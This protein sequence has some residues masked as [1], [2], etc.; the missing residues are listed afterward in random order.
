[1]QKG[2]VRVLFSA[3]GLPEKYIQDGDSYQWQVE[4]TVAAI[5]NELGM[6]DLDYRICYQS[7]V[8]RLVWIGPATDV[9][10]EAAAEARKSLVIVPVAFVSE[11][12]ETLVELDIE[13]A[14]L[15]HAKGAAG[16]TR[17]PALGVQDGYIQSLEEMVRNAISRGNSTAPDEG[18]RIC[19]KNFSACP[20]SDAS[21]N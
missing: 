12:S 20:C 2:E 15:A 8:G 3:H 6:P 21:E 4:H 19:P 10:I 13:Y 7:R 18:R 17:V 1:V 11:H 9:E 14:E 5:V 16:Y